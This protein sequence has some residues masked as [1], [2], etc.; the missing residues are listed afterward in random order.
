MYKFVYFA[1]LINNVVKTFSKLLNMFAR[2]AVISNFLFTEF[3]FFKI[4]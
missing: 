4:F 2:K 1:Q 3:V